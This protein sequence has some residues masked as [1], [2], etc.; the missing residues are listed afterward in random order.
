[1]H[2]TN[3]MGNMPWFLHTLSDSVLQKDYAAG[4]IAAGSDQAIWLIECMNPT[5]ER[6]FFVLE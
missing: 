1:M 4:S 3:W 2:R 5:V 6:A